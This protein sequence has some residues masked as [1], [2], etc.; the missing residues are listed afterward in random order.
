VGLPE[1][2]KKYSSRSSSLGWVGK[3]FIT[4]FPKGS[5]NKSS[6]PNWTLCLSVTRSRMFSDKVHV[7]SC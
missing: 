5:S 1:A 3:R 7:G 2:V 6:V 4:E